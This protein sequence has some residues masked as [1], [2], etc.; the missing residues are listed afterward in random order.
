[1]SVN[2]LPRGEYDLVDYHLVTQRLSLKNRVQFPPEASTGIG[3]KVRALAL[4]RL[5][6]NEP[7]IGRWQEAC[8]LSSSL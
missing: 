8:L 5:R 7:I 3:R 1:V 4:E 6:G 2:L